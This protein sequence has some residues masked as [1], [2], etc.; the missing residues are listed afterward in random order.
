MGVGNSIPVRLVKKTTVQASDGTW[1]TQPDE[2]YN[3]WAEIKNVNQFRDYQNGQ[4][5]LGQAKRFKIRFRFDLYPDADWRIK[6]QNSEWTVTSINQDKEKRF[7]W[8]LIA[9]RK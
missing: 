7:F 4:T 2:V 3:V 8:I 9:T 1:E 6:Y 5:Q